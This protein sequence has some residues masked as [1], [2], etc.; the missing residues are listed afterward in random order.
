[1]TNN[2]NI[3]I[4][5]PRNK[6]KVVTTAGAPIMLNVKM[7][8]IGSGVTYEPYDGEYVVVPSTVSQTLETRS[9]RLIDDVVVTEVP[10]AEVPNPAGGSTIV[11][12]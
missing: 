8:A 6:T 3:K 10:I 7:K 11:I 9:K 2:V 12:G 5:Q 1:M 4:V